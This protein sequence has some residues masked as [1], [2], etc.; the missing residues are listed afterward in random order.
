MKIDAKYV[1]YYIEKKRTKMGYSRE[2]R[3]QL[4]KEAGVKVTSIEKYETGQA[5]P[6]SRTLPGLCAALKVSAWSLLNG[7]DQPQNDRLLISLLKITEVIRMLWAAIIGLLVMNFAVWIQPPVEKLM[8]AAGASEQSF[9][10]GVCDGVFAG[11]KIVG[12]VVFAYGIASYIRAKAEREN[13]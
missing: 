5:L 9:L 6:D 7:E 13:D 2:S 8:S 4:A 10:A 1:G 11:V 12:V 3:E